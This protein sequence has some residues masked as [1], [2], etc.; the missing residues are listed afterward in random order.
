MYNLALFVAI[1]TGL[2]EVIKRVTPIKNRYLPLFSLGLGLL[3]SVFYYAGS[4]QDKVFV[5]I[6][7]GLAASGLFDHSKIMKNDK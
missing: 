7:I 3:A 6:V 2:T 1:V 5:G 4:I